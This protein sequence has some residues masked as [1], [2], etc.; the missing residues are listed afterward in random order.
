MTYIYERL[1]THEVARRLKADENAGWSYEGALALAEY[2][3]QY[4]ED[5]NVPMELDIVALR[6]DFSEYESL[7]EFNKNYNKPYKDLDAVRDETTVIEIEGTGR[8][9]AQDF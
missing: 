9:I 8:F 4:V 7:E 2:L 1:S 3:E 5:V 6:C